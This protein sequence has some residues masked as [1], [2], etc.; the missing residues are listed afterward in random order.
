[1]KTD[2]IFK[3]LL[4]KAFQPLSYSGKLAT[5]EKGIPFPIIEITKS[6]GKV[7]VVTRECYMVC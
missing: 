4:P 6:N 5:K 7:S 3:V 1:M 2:N